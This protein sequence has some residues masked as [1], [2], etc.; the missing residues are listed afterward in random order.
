M[1]AGKLRHRITLEA[2][3]ESV[4]SGEPSIPWPV[5]AT[6]WGS[7]EGL[8]GTS[9]SG[10]TAE[11]GVRFRIRYRSDITPRWR[12][13]LEGTARKFQIVVPPMDPD[14]RGRELILV[15]QE[16]IA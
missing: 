5:Q 11:A 12:V 9:R 10:I 8:S 3:N 7:M 16:L 15:T 4:T 1:Q 14:G 6:V 2:P 13:G